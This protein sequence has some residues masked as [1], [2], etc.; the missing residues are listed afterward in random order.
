M[1]GRN[2]MLILP[3]VPQYGENISASLVSSGE[4]PDSRGLKSAPPPATNP[5][6]SQND[7]DDADGNNNDEV[8]DDDDEADQ[9]GNVFEI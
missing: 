3:H 5:F 7:D 6:S 1:E 9:D 2:R 4:I 8:D